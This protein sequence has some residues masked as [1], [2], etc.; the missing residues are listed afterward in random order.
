MCVLEVDQ[1]AACR[2][3]CHWPSQEARSKQTGRER[4]SASTNPRWPIA[5]LPLHAASKNCHKSW[6]IKVGFRNLHWYKPHK[7][8]LAASESLCFLLP[9]CISIK[10]TGSPELCTS[11]HWRCSRPE[12]MGLRDSLRWEA[13]L[14]MAQVLEPDDL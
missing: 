12:R 10:Q 11:H 3:R 6:G 7:P 1:P 5:Q 14:S 2:W 8:E 9:S 13:T 4:T